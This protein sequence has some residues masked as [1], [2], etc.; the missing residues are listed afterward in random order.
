MI[1]S[2]YPFYGYGDFNC[3]YSIGR[4]GSLWKKQ[5]KKTSKGML[6]YAVIDGEYCRVSNVKQFT[7]LIERI[8]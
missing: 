3:I 7:E 6:H 4:G 1:F 2:P 8:L 5:T